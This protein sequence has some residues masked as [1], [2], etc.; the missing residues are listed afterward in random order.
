M[1]ENELGRMTND[2]AVSSDIAS[3]VSFSDAGLDRDPDFNTPPPRLVESLLR[4]GEVM[5]G[6]SFISSSLSARMSK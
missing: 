3:L 5:S 1:I 6:E 4:E 2:W